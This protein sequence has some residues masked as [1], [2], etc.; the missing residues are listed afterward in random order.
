VRKA[1]C[2]FVWG[3]LWRGL[4]GSFVWGT[5]RPLKRQTFHRPAQAV[6]RVDFE[7]DTQDAIDVLG[8]MFGEGSV[9]LFNM[10]KR[11]LVTF[12]NSK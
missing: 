4:Y 11:G 5:L 1:P 8:G 10:A 2:P 7:A 3:T 12:C 9:V 6:E